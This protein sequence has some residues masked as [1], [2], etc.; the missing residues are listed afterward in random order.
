MYLQKD[1]KVE[2]Q[3]EGE[4]VTL[5]QVQKKYQKTLEEMMSIVQKYLHSDPYSREELASLLSITVIIISL[6]FSFF[7][8]KRKD[9]Y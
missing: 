2:T 8:K 3:N 5:I 1:L 6:Y 4:I 9:K 7:L